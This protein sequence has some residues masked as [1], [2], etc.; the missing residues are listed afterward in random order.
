MTLL[1]LARTVSQGAAAATI[2]ATRE[3]HDTISGSTAQLPHISIDVQTGN[4]G[5]LSRTA[6]LALVRTIGEGGMGRVHLAR[7]RSLDRDV[8]VKT[9][10]EDATPDA[11]A[12]LFREARLTGSLEHPGVIPVHALGVDDTGGPLL[13]MKRVESIG[14]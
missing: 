9:L 13:V 2:T 10:K 7:Q 5:L 1:G 6:H 11:I 12:G 8:A 14:R 4:G 3:I